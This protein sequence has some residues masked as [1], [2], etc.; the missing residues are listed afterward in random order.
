LDIEI[1]DVGSQIEI[2]KNDLVLVLAHTMYRSSIELENGGRDICPGLARKLVF[3]P[4]ACWTSK[5]IGER[6]ET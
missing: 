5:Y 2:Q 1:S 4:Q 6:R 3:Q